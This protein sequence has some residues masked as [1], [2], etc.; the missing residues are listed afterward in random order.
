M[1]IVYR[2]RMWDITNDC[3]KES[4]RWA[5]KEAIEHIGGESI[6]AGVEVDDGFL[7]HEVDGMTARGFDPRFP[8][9]LDFP[10]YV[11]P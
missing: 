8:P 1:A 2:F 5:T 11:R 7:G 4:A 3:F 6:S 9:S 10:P